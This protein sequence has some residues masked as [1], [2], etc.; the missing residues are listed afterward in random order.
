MYFCVFCRRAPIG[1]QRRG[2]E[3]DAAF[4]G[5]REMSA[6]RYGLRPPDLPDRVPKI[7]SLKMS[8]RIYLSI[9]MYSPV[10]LFI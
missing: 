9:R 4:G 6:P 10:Y 7:A 2:E 1:A 3:T 5:E 8:D